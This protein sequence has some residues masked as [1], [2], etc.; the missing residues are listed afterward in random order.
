MA[1]DTFLQG[2]Q[3]GA[4]IVNQG[5]QRRER[6][7]QLRAEEAMQ[8]IR[9]RET[10]D[11]MAV[12]MEELEMKRRAEQREIDLL[13]AGKKI[14]D[15]LLEQGMSN[16]EAM[17]ASIAPMSR[18][19]PE[20]AFK[21]SQSYGNLKRAQMEGKPTPL[22]PSQVAANEARASASLAAADA[23]KARAKVDEARVAG[24]LPQRGMIIKTN[25]DGST[26]VIT[27]ADTGNP[28]ALTKT[29][30]SQ[31]QQTQASAMDMIDS[32]N[33]LL[34]LIDNETIG[35][36]AFAESW[37]KDRIL[38]QR[39]PELASEK[40]AK[41]EVIAASLRSAVAN[42]LKT[43]GPLAEAERKEILRGFPQINE[44]LNSPKKAKE[45]IEQSREMAAT[46]ALVT[47][48]KMKSSVPKDAVLVLSDRQLADLVKRGLI[49][50]EMAAQAY[51]LKHPE[52]VPQ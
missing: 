37:I 45:A 5:W 39:F 16:D 50:R 38:A 17:A 1:D 8:R 29:N 48:N 12:M 26:E 19:S 24:T 10:A 18:I 43:P 51:M 36:Q 6:M 28:D 35:V 46:I 7:M 31:V 41:A 33:R 11:R 40:R 22:D 47:A 25:P 15:E 52:L 21:L 34:P 9:E 13:A 23:S 42:T 14:H 49:T 44:P 3:L 2:A 27:N 20:T 4:N 32:A 30:F